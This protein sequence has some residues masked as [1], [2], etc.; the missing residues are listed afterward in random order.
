M[1]DFLLGWGAQATLGHDVHTAAERIFQ[2]HKESAE[3][4]KR[5]TLFETYQKVDVALFGILTARYRSKHAH[6]T[7]SVRRGNGEYLVAFLIDEFG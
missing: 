3:I 7:C 5:P 1:Q 4:Q 6:I 2:I